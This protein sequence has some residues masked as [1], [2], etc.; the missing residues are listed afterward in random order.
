VLT[1][2]KLYATL[3]NMNKIY[4]VGGSYG[5]YDDYHE[6]NVRAFANRDEAEACKITLEKQFDMFCKAVRK[7]G[8]MGIPKL[9]EP[10]IDS[11]ICNQHTSENIEYYV[12]E[13]PFGNQE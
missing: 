5:D 10:M 1:S 7:C 6:W 13:V 8:L 11:E 12:S 9:S 2:L 3:L 4:I